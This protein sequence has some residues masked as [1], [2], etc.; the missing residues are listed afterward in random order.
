MKMVVALL[1]FASMSMADTIL[2]DEAI[3]GALS[4]SVTSVGTFADDVN[5]VRGHVS[6]GDLNVLDNE[7]WSAALNPGDSIDS[8]SIVITNYSS[9]DF[10]GQ[11]F[12][13]IPGVFAQFTLGSTTKPIHSN[14]T[15]NVPI[16]A[17]D[18]QYFALFDSFNSFRD[19]SY[20]WEWRVNVSDTPPIP[21]PGTFVLFG[22]AALAYGVYRRRRKA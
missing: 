7:A 11:P 8:A 16:P 5:V 19:L 18:L 22:V 20:D 17:G 10:N 6:A 21:E 2:W 13:P 1:V 3:D 4:T 12:N 9:L 14:G 15:I